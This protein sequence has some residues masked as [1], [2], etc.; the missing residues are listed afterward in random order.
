VLRSSYGAC[1]N[2]VRLLNR[3]YESPLT[4]EELGDLVNEVNHQ[5]D[6][7]TAALATATH[8]VE[9]SA[10]APD[11]LARDYLIHA[12]LMLATGALP[13]APPHPNFL[14]DEIAQCRES[15]ARRL[16]AFFPLAQARDDYVYVAAGM[17]GFLGHHDLALVLS[18]MDCYSTCPG[19]GEEFLMMET[20]LNPFWS[21]SA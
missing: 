9:L 11:E 21:V 20:G 16:S 15:G 3:A 10:S 1:D 14:A 13:G 17:A 5:G 6:P 7:S 12:G 4:S 2:V 19:C 18:N 8:P